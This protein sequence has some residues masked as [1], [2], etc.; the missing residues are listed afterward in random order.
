MAVGMVVHAMIRKYPE[1]VRERAIELR[2][3]GM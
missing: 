3:K 2:R 1:E